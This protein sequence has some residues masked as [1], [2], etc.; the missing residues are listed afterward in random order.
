MHE[1]GSVVRLGRPARSAQAGASTAGDGDDPGRFPTFSSTHLPTV[2]FAH[3][4]K[5]HRLAAAL[6]QE[7][8]AERAG[9]S[10]RAISDLERGIHRAPYPD[11][12]RLLAEALQIGDEVRAELI[13]AATRARLDEP[14]PAPPVDRG[15]HLPRPMTPLLGREQEETTALGLLRRADVRLVT[16]TGV[17]GVGKTRLAIQVAAQIAE[18]DPGE[19]VYVPLDAI[20]DPRLVLPAIAQAFGPRADG[21]HPVGQAPRVHLRDRRVLLVVDNV[22]QVLDAAPDLVELLAACPGLTMLVTSRAALRV[23]GEHELTVPPLA[24]PSLDEKAVAT[25]DLSALAEVPSVQLFVGRATARRATFE[26]TVDN[27]PA[28]AEICR[29]LDGIPLAIELAAAR[30]GLLPVEEIAARLDDRFRLLTDGTRGAPARQQTLRAT[31]DWSHALL[32]EPERALVRRLSV[33]VDGWTL[34]AAE[35][36]CDGGPR[37]EVRGTSEEGGHSTL[38]T[39]PSTLDLLASLVDKSLVVAEPAEPAGLGGTRYRFLETLGAYAHEQLAASELE[40]DEARHRHAVYF[41][42]LAER[43]EPELMGPEQV[44]WLRRLELDYGNLRAALQWASEREVWEEGLRLAGALWKFWLFGNRLHEGREVLSALLS[45]VPPRAPQRLKAL[46]TA[47]YLDFYLGERTEDGVLG[48]RL[49][50]LALARELGDW[51]QIGRFLVGVASEAIVRGDVERARGYLDEALALARLHDDSWLIQLALLTLGMLH[52]SVADLGAAR[53]F[54]EDAIAVSALVP[55][56]RLTAN[57][58]VI[59]ADV[60][61]L[62]GEPDRAGALGRKS[63][64]VRRGLGDAWGVG[65]TLAILARADVARGRFARAARLLGAS[66]GLRCS[67]GVE[68]QVPARCLDDHERAVEATR[69]ALDETVFA[70]AWTE[71]QAMTLDEAVEYATVA[72]PP[73]PEGGRPPAQASGGPLTRREREV[74]TLMARG[75]TNAQIAAELVISERTVDTHAEHIRDKLDVRSRAE[76]AAWAARHGLVAAS[77]V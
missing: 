11:T 27:A 5:R 34:E 9:L 55:D 22:E 3:L 60:V 29:R 40:R 19:V 6:S 24:V 70:A 77:P 1:P 26:L 47:G 67:I 46:W 56:A 62:Q 7:A 31:L 2:S 52:W 74:A 71:G 63:L 18:H 76:I 16:L 12:I 51:S 61:L 41:R 75:L 50:G 8:L 36:V 4:L 57:A 21:R 13:E 35:A 14:T 69:L 68:F 25:P 10:A 33:F 72:E 64:L 28:V 42:G 38:A 44:V 48:P 37:G 23:D 53:R 54:L 49:E 73:R 17:G 15:V 65:V 30:V 45:L 59:L 32:S 20:R 66:E 43:A 39:D 58:L